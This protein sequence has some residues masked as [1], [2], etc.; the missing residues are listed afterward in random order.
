V[1][2]ALVFGEVEQAGQWREL[3]VVDGGE[4]AWLDVL[5]SGASAVLGAAVVPGAAQEVAVGAFLAPYVARSE[6]G[7]CR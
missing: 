6:S 2:L 5:T 3:D 4:L 7:A 1:G